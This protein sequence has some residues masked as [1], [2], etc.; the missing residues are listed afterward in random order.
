VVLPVGAL[1]ALLDTLA[2]DPARGIAAP[3]A[4]SRR[5]PNVAE[6][7]GM[8]FS[9]RT[10]RMRHLGIGEAVDLAQ[11]SEWRPVAG[12]SGCAMLVSREVFDAA[13]LLP[14][15]YFF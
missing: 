12:V 2:A 14:E 10:G 4:V 1:R 6:S 11:G 3:V 9:D 7:A 5:R 13:G 15:P 8:R